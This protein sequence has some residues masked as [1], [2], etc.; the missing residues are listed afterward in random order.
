MAKTEKKR[1][2]TSLSSSTLTDTV[3][4]PRLV[5]DLLGSSLRV[6]RYLSATGS[7]VKRPAVSP[8]IVH[9][10][11]DDSPRA[12]FSVRRSAALVRDICQSNKGRSTSYFFTGTFRDD[13]TYSDFVDGLARFHR[14]LRR[15]FPAVGYVGIPELTKAGRIHYHAVFFGLPSVREMK[16]RFGKRVSTL[17]GRLVH[18]WKYRFTL[19]WTKSVYGGCSRGVDGRFVGVDDFDSPNHRASISKVKHSLAVVNYVTKYMVKDMLTTFVPR[20]RRCYF[21]GGSLVRPR[22]LVFTDTRFDFSLNIPVSVPVPSF[23]SDSDFAFSVLDSRF[24]RFTVDFYDDW[25][26]SVPWVSSLFVDK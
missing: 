9:D 14:A 17:D 11:S 7:F 2:A 8:S 5:V 6:R 26:K 21:S 10:D 4:T 13:V 1:C 15:E 22:R 18:A 3:H 16:A 24:G 23:P 19:L 20:S 12:S 25:K